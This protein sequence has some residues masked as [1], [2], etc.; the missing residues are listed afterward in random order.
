MGWKADVGKVYPDSMRCIAGAITLVMFVAACSAK[1]PETA[2]YFEE[3]TGLPLCHSAEVQNFQVGEHDYEA[4][5]TYGVRLRLSVSCHRELLQQISERLGTACNPSTACE[6][7][8]KNNWSYDVSPS[9][10][11][12]VTFILRAI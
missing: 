6:F 10:N 3:V 11:G 5:F 2:D 8:D 12:R 9:E 4:D 1:R 7:M